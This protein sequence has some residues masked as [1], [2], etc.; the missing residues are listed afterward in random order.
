MAAR[1]YTGVAVD[2]A[3][4]TLAALA[5]LSR[6]ARAGRFSGLAPFAMGVAAGLGGAGLR[7]AGVALHAHFNENDLYH[8]IQIAS[9]A[10]LYR[11]G[12]ALPPDRSERP[13]VLASPA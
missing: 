1:G 11:G 12:L 8:L 9:L 13:P 5:L 7:H 10:M 3:L 6:T 2:A 4:G